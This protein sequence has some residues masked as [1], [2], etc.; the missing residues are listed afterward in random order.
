MLGENSLDNTI[1]VIQKGIYIEMGRLNILPLVDVTSSGIRIHMWL[2][3][4]VDL[5]REEGKNNCP[6]FC[7]MKGY[8][9][10][11]AA[12]ESVFHPIMEEIKIHR[13]RD[14]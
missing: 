5:L 6:A 8:M 13:D 11:A 14:L 2:D 10:S 12:I 4:L 1:E 3:R 9:L 7:D